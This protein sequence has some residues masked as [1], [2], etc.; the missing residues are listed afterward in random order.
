MS[1]STSSGVSAATVARWSGTIRFRRFLRCSV[2]EPP[3]ARMNSESNRGETRRIRDMTCDL[4][5]RTSAKLAF[6]EG[7]LVHL[8]VLDRAV[9]EEASLAEQFAVI[10]GNRDPGVVRDQV[11]QLFDDAIEVADRVDLAVAERAKLRAI[12][13]LLF[14]AGE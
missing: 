1:T 8:L 9:P 10:G 3:V 2:A 4:P 12:E 13:E 11:E 7:D 14:A 5:A 6:D